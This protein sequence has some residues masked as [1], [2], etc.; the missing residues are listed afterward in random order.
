MNEFERR[1]I[2]VASRQQDLNNVLAAM[3][4]NVL[5]ESF[6]YTYKTPVSPLVVGATQTGIVQMM[7]DSWFVLHAISSCVVTQGSYQW[8]TDSG[9]IEIEVTD[10]GSG[11]ELYSNPSSAG[12]LTATVNRPSTGIPFLFPVPHLIP[13]N[14]NVKID[15]TQFADTATAYE[16]VYVFFTGTRVALV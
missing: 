15:V 16:A 7:S 2:E 12:V 11:Y 10:S 13:P 5:K 14:S 9:S 1:M 4:Q 3:G 6:G 8:F